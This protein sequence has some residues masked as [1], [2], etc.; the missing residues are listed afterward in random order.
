[1]EFKGY[2][3]LWKAVIRP[4]RAQYDVSDMGP[5]DFMIDTLRIKRTDMEIEN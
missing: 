4:P 3:S 1:M 5:A 2:S